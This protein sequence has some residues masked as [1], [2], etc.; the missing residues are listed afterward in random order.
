MIAE[1]EIRAGE[2]FEFGDNWQS[3]LSVLDEERIAA[4]EASLADMLESAD[5]TNK[6]F[7]D[8]GSGSGL[9]SLA[10]RRLGA[11]VHS[12]D[13]DPQSV[14][15]TAQ[16]R[17]RYFPD[18]EDWIVQQGSVLD[19]AFLSTLGT[20]DVV[21]S[22][23]VLHHTGAMW[24]ALN[25]VAPLVGDNGKLFISI[26]NDQDFISAYWARVKRLYCTSS[27]V[28]RWMILATVGAYAKLGSAAVRLARRRL[29][30]S[31]SATRKPARGMSA[32]HDLRD[33][34]GGY[35]FEVATPEA[36]FDVYR[37]KGFMLLRLSTCGGRLGCNQFVFQRLSPW[38]IEAGGVAANATA[39][40]A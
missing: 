34:V 6:R 22:W 10:A 39:R 3:F 29:S 20:F 18:D 36:I 25:N 19:E 17:R 8:V 28:V 23:G 30:G 21:Y 32:F 2:R 16:L 35:P 33:W 37:A 40:S 9:F 1:A 31:E 7:L 13:Y 24:K 27:P 15:C 4:A 11:H 12:F 38:W 26:Y 5:L 14:A